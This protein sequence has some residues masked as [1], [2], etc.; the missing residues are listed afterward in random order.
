MTVKLT[1]VQINLTDYSDK[2]VAKELYPGI[3]T[4]LSVSVNL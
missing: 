2:S 4:R 1:A 3:I